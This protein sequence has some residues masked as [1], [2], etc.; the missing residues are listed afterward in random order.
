MDNFGD[1]V[2]LPDS[3]L[4]PEA[5]FVRNRSLLVLHSGSGRARPGQIGAGRAAPGQRCQQPL[6]DQG[7]PS[8]KFG[9][10]RIQSAVPDRRVALDP[11]GAEANVLKPEKRRNSILASLKPAKSRMVGHPEVI[12]RSE[13]AVQARP[14]QRRCQ[15]SIPKPTHSSMRRGST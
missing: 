6:G 13:W 1:A 12:G 15:M 8:I 11:V 4:F 14:I 10:W 3:A 2:P 7:R 5:A 9:E